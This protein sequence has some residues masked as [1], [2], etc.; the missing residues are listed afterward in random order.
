MNTVPLLF[1]VCDGIAVITLNRPQA[2][3]AY[4]GEMGRLWTEAYQRCDADDAI[5]AVVVTGS[6]KAFCAGAD[7]SESGVFD[8]PEM[9]EDFTACPV[10]PAWRVRKPVIAACNGHA[11]GLGFSLALQCD[12]RILANEAQYGLLQ[13]RRG[14]LADACSHWILPRLVGMEKALDI[15]LTGRRMNGEQARAMGLASQAV[16][17]GEVL[18][19][20][21]AMASELVTHSAPLVMGMAKRLVWASFRYDLHDMEALETRCLLHTMGRADALEG[22]SAWLEK[23]KPVWQGSVSSDWPEDYLP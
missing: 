14:V 23:R 11:I 15:L 5:R 12:F 1:D 19:V 2:M 13:V 18:P 4:T 9:A 16:A 21:M 8:A 10:F 7:L 3:N 22:G 20:A 17:A 6:G